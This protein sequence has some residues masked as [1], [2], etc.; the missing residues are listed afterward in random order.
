MKNTKIGDLLKFYRKEKIKKSVREASEDIGIHYTYL[1]RLENGFSEPSDEVLE[2]ITKKYKLNKEEAVELF[3][4]VKITP[5]FE[6]IM[7][8]L[9]ERQSTEIMF[10]KNK[11]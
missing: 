8:S 5:S 11:K 3:S 7:K 2:L 1:S 6:K 4:A 9:G 10:R